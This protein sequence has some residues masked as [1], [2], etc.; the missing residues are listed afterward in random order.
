MPFTISHCT[1]ADIPRFFEIVS[2]AFS[3]DHEYIDSVFPD[4]YTPEG[5]AAGAERMLT[6]MRTDPNTTFLKVVN[7]EAQM[8]AAAKWNIYNGVIPSKPTLSGDHW[9]NEEEQ[10]FAQYMFDGYL[11]PR[12]KEIR[13]SGGNLVGA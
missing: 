8:I 1:E 4:H 7:D 11:I 12:L 5:R 3:H 13:D 9:K 6:S 2:L 10:E